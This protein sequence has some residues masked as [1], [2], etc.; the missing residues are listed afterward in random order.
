MALLPFQNSFLQ[1]TPLGAF[2]ASLSLLPLALFAFLSILRVIARP[3]ATTLSPVYVAVMVYVVMVTVFGFLAYGWAY[4]GIF[5]TDKAI[6]AAVQWI[7]MAFAVAAGAHCSPSQAR[8]ALTFAWLANLAGFAVFGGNPDAVGASAKSIGFSSEPSQFGLV[9]AIIGLTLACL[10]VR[11]IWRWTILTTSGAAILLS[12]SKGAVAVLAIVVV[13]TGLV[14]ARHDRRRLLQIV[15]VLLLGAGGLVYFA[16][17][18]IQYDIANF[19]STVT[20]LSGVLTALAIA[21]DHPFG[22]GLGSFYPAFAT[23]VPSTWPTIRSL[24]GLQIDLSETLAYS[25]SDDR[26]ISAKAFLFDTLI[27]FGW[28]GALAL[29]GIT[30]RLA[31]QWLT[32]TMPDAVWL[33]M[34]LCFAIFAM[35]T[36]NAVIPMYVIP[37]TFGFAWGARRA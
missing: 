16:A 27:Y 31:W 10:T 20:R 5:L 21:I 30:G 6:L 32:A 4:K 33:A 37:M 18:K 14:R 35:S 13:V 2:G 25:Y 26:N 36:Y 28:P 17:S 7:F 22:V 9:T 15:P 1:R 34:A 24:L 19:T 8:C 12:G 11:P 29:L 3:A 23:T